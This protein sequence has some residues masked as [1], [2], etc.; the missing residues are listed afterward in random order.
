MKIDISR[1]CLSPREMMRKNFLYKLVDIE[2]HDVAGTRIQVSRDLY[3]FN[4]IWRFVTFS[5]LRK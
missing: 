2:N 5:F 3:R 4:L 1:P